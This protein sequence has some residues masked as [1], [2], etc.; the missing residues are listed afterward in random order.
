MGAIEGGVARL[1]EVAEREAVQLARQVARGEKRLDEFL[2][3]VGRAGIADHPAV[4]VIG[5]GAE[6]A[7]EIR[8][9]VPDDHVEAQ[10]LAVC[11]LCVINGISGAVTLCRYLHVLPCSTHKGE[12]SLI[13]TDIRGKARGRGIDVTALAVFTDPLPTVLD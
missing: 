2:G 4:N 12:H 9:L 11:H 3:T 13:E 10:E 6:T 8:H 1:L 5:D 7:L